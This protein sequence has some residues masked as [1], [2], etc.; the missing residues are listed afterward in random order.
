MGWNEPDKGKD[1]WKGKDQPP[2]LDEAF[3][4]IHEKFKKIFSGGTVKLNNKSSNGGI[5]FLAGLVALIIVAIWALSGIFIGLS[6]L[7]VNES[8]FFE[9]VVLKDVPNIKQYCFCIL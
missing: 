2:D 7:T 5:G 4:R 3:K 8:L 1:P 9:Q 6:R